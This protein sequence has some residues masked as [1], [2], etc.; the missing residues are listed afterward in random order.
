MAANAS[1]NKVVYSKWIKKGTNTFIPTDNSQILKEVDAGV[2]DL[3]VADGIGFYMV[4]RELYLDELLEFPSKMHRTVLSSIK[5]FWT[6]KEKFKEYKF[7]F[8]RGILL[9]GKPGCGKSC[10]ISLCM[11]YVTGEL[12]GV[13][14]P[15]QSSS[16]LELYSKAIPEIFRVIERERPIVIIFEDIENMCSQGSGSESLLLN[17]L[18]GLDQLENVVYLATTNYIE[19]LK[20]RI[21]NRPSRFDRR[22]YVPFLNYSDR[23]FYFKNKLK[24]NDIEAN[25]IEKWATD[26]EGLSIAHLA[27][28]IK[29]IVIFGADYQETIDTL[30]EMNEF[31][32]LHSSR[33]E[34][35]SGKIGFQN[36]SEEV[37]VPS[38]NGA[39][40]SNH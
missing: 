22:I 12:N 23:L 10:I 13:V 38:S 14:I 37:C 1:E 15:L 39:I 31:A 27:E 16:D 33:Y 9:H 11:K 4:K 25:D 2:Y 28:L 19:H 35:E 30:K 40:H 5:D 7:A 18:D 32:A 26:T 34:K 20:E 36:R 3:R 6:R 29:S 8:K 17:V 21:I 24:A